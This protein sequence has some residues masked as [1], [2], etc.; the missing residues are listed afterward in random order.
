MFDNDLRN[1]GVTDAARIP[2]LIDNTEGSPTRGRH[3]LAGS[4]GAVRPNSMC[5]ATE[6]GTPGMGRGREIQSSGIRVEG[7]GADGNDVHRNWVS[8]SALASISIH[9]FVLNPAAP[10]VPQESPNLHNTVRG[11][12]VTRTGADTAAIDP[13]ADGIAVLSSGPVGTIT[14]PSYSNRIVN[15]R[16]FDNARHGIS[17]GRLTHDNVVARNF[18]VGNGRSGIW[19][20]GPASRGSG[21]LRGAHDNTL[22]RNHGRGNA[23]FDGT[24]LN[25]NCD[26]NAWRANRLQTFNQLCVVG[27]RRP[28]GERIGLNRARSSAE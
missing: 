3:V 7:P 14:M 23:E 16:S 6:I 13:F 27:R 4:P 1:V 12:T 22:R 9:S 10:N 25:P 2:V 26:G 19:V 11:N 21:D 20:A 15:N 28:A 18:V 24:D 8:K 5:G 17:L